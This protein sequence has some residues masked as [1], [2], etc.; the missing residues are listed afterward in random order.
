MIR[1]Y[2]EIEMSNDM[3]LL[4]EMID[5]AAAGLGTVS[6]ARPVDDCN[7]KPH[8]VLDTL[9]FIRALTGDVLLYV[10]G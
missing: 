4:A 9:T 1:T 5:V 3:V 8:L 7:Q 6:S 2:G 10:K